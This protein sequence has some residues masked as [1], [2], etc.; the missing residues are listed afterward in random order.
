MEI[1]ES[2]DTTL[3]VIGKDEVW[4]HNWIKEKPSRLGLG[5]FV[6]VRSELRHYRD[7]GGR[8]DILGYRG[9]LDTYYEIEVMLGECDADHGFRTLDY[10]ARERLL[11]PNAR[12]VAV[13]VAEDLSGRYKTLIETLP[14]FLPFVGIEINVLKLGLPGGD[15]AT[16]D[17]LIVAQSDD[18]I[19][20]AGDE[21]S[22]AQQNGS[23]PKDRTWWESK[24]SPQFIATV[25]EIA[26]FC[27]QQIGP[28]RTDYSAAE[29]HLSEKRQTLLASNVAAIEWSFCLSARRHRRSGRCSLRFLPA[30]PVEVGR[31]WR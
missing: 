8:L 7:N 4:L 23:M 6:I 5:E 18:L 14:K 17:T 24:E 25:D 22:S 21:P 31:D 26:R 3:R 11:K 20:D 29:L 9:D 16:I 27:T 13:L 10:W 15:V 28:S 19:T 1:I 12:H 2:I 30:S